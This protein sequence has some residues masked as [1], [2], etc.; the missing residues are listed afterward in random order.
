MIH[1]H[2][3]PLSQADAEAKALSL[4]ERDHRSVTAY[5][6]ISIELP[7]AHWHY[8]HKSGRKR[9]CRG[10]RKERERVLARSRSAVA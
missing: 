7:Y 3:Q 6:C 1:C 5:E 4:R 8:G 9:E 2:K 10:C